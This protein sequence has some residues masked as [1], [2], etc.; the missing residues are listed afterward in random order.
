M[1]A[2]PFGILAILGG[3]FIGLAVGGGEK[4][5]PTFSTPPISI[6]FEKK[7]Q[8]KSVIFPGKDAL[9]RKFADGESLVVSG[10]SCSGCVVNQ[11]DQLLE[12][13]DKFANIIVVFDSKEDDIKKVYKDSPVYLVVSS[14][15]LNGYSELE[16]PGIGWWFV[17][18]SGKV[19]RNQKVGGEK[20]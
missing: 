20:P 13:A 14:S 8:G 1:R 3:V 12:F 9:G 10:G 11:L 17:S 16:L 2:T 5:A 18:R 15:D 7:I 6:E 4:S 19:I